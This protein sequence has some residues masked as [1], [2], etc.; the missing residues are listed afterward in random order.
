MSLPA[1]SRPQIAVIGAGPAGLMAAEAA[2]QAGADVTVYEAKAS[3]GRKFLIAGRGGLNLTHS[4]PF[5][6]FVG[7]YP[8][9]RTMVRRWLEGFDAEALRAWAADLGIETF[10]GS[11][12]RV[13]PTDMKAIPLLRAWL[14]RLGAQ[15]VRLQTR[16]RWL[17]F[18]AAGGARMQG[19]DGEWQLQADAF[20]LAL[21]GGSWPQ[22][23][24]DGRWCEVLAGH[25]VAV[26][27]LLASNCGWTCAWSEHLRAR[28][29]GQPL[30]AVVAHW[31][32]A[33]GQPR[34]RRGE[35]VLTEHGVEGSLLYAA[36]A[37]LRAQ[38]QREGTATW[39]LDL[40]PDIPEAEL[41]RA[42]A[43]PRGK[44]TLGEHLRRQ[45]GVDAAKAAL[46][47]EGASAEEKSDA[48]AM[49][50]RLKH[51]AL[52]FDGMRPMAEAISTAGGVRAEAID[53]RGQLR[54]LPGVFVAGEMLDWDAPTG[55]YLLTACFASGR[56]AG[57]SAA[58]WAHWMSPVGR[59]RSAVDTIAG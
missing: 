34:R 9:G 11:S 35:C 22:L 49:A 6:T 2:A 47:F 1:P 44:R 19:P 39:T 21:G 56:E 10:V 13:F 57:R 7:R 17:G 36:G 45:T 4:D 23:G 59:P 3:P 15:G 20:V 18:D 16:Q 41:A 37:D 42:L 12:G 30:K 48:V 43:K 8:E 27:P 24:S 58:E 50:Q 55:G 46:F 52:R 5:E 51:R 26:A 31:Q 40:C 29:A 33:D 54:A 14:Q 25:G 38:W 32:G 53:E 28:F